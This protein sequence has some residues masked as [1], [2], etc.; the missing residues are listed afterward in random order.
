MQK[1]GPKNAKIFGNHKKN[2]LKIKKKKALEKN[3][4]FRKNAEKCK[5]PPP[6]GVKWGK[7]VEGGLPSSTKQLHFTCAC[8]M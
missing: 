5:T 2:V 6:P 8:I 1:H 7:V 3:T 4:F